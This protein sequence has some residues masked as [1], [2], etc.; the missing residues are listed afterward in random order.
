MGSLDGLDLPACPFSL[1]Y[2]TSF[3]LANKWGY[4]A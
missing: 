3:S 4:L 2:E 1:I